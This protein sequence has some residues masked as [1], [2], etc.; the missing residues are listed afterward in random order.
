MTRLAK[1]LIGLVIGLLVFT[2]GFAA[3][4]VY[5]Y[6]AAV[7]SATDEGPQDGVFD[8]EYTPVPPYLINNNGWTSLAT[9]L[10]FDL[11]AIPADVTIV[12]AQ[13]TV[14]VGTIEGN[15]SLA[16][17]GYS[18]SGSAALA[19]FSAG[20]LLAEK[21]V[22]AGGTSTFTLDVTTFVADLIGG[23]HAFAGFNLRE[24]PANAY[25]W[26][27]MVMN[28]QPDVS[29]VLT[30]QY[31][32][33]RTVGLDIKPKSMPNSIN[34]KSRGNIPVAILSDSTFYA[35]GEVS[36][37][38][39]TFGRIGDETSLRMCDPYGNDVNDDGLLDL[40]CYFDNLATG[41]LPSDTQGVLNGQTIGGVMIK[42]TDSVRILR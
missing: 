42:G 26:Q 15:R 19:D 31:E 30:V 3:T 11:S 17:S 37:A 35:P 5:V 13:L 20:A 10:E 34:P 21:S 39:L 41:F 38:S 18:G 9:A 24:S 12:S 28:W 25:G 8:V 29:P 6:P 40:T 23:G 2:S 14:G 32:A 22:P 7:K 33:I 27:V 4:T 16:I 1:G 36:V